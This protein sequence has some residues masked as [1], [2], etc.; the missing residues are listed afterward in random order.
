M[1]KLIYI[2]FLLFLGCSLNSN[3]SFWSKTQKAEKDISIT[4]TLFED[5]K[6]NKNEFNPKL[7]I[8]LPTQNIKNIDY[9]LNND[10]YTTEK[11]L[12]NIITSLTSLHKKKEIK[13]SKEDIDNVYIKKTLNRLKSVSKI[14]PNFSSAETFTI[15]GKKCKI[16]GSNWEEPLKDAHIIDFADC[17]MHYHT[18]I[19]EYIAS[20]L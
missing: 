16:A 12:D 18:L 13:S 15:N 10:G 20:R 1:N 2:L 11:I 4:K 19:K 9:N 3:S 8:N 14:I 7:K 17:F 6:P 5:I